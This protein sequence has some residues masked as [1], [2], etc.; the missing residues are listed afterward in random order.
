MFAITYRKIFLII[1]IVVMVGSVA[2]VGIL[3]LNQGI[4]FT[5]GSLTEVVY[6]T[7]PDRDEVEKVVEIQ[8]L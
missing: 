6:D 2:I 7:A 8:N 3:G 4:D 1:A 5:G